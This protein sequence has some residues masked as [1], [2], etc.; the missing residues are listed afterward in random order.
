MPTHRIPLFIEPHAVPRK[1]RIARV[2]LERDA[3]IHLDDGLVQGLGPAD[4]EGEDGRAG[5]V[6]NPEEVF[7]AFGG[8]EGVAGAFA[9]EERVG[10]NCRAQPATGVGW[11]GG[12]R[13]KVMEAASLPDVVNLLRLELLTSWNLG[14][15]HSLEHAPDALLIRQ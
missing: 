5:L 8:D 9:L 14:F 12:M 10:G 6:A 4:L 2:P 3:L 7:E 11:L 1:L 13:S 15:S